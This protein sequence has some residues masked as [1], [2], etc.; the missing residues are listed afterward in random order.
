MYKHVLIAT[1]G[2]TLSTEA[3]G[4]AMALSKRLG[5]RTTVLMVTKRFPI[6]SSDPDQIAAMK[7]EFERQSSE[8]ARR[9]LAAAQQQA[10]VLGVACGT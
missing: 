10:T 9:H 5:A 8:Q 7:G 3:I 4:K 2:S 1:D 6:Y